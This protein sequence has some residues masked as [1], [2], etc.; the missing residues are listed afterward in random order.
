MKVIIFSGTTE[1]R[2]AAGKLS[3]KGYDITV[4]VATKLGREAMDTELSENGADIITGRLGPVELKELLKKFEVCIDATHP[5]ATEITENLK[6]V[7]KEEDVHYFRLIRD[8]YNTVSGS[9]KEKDSDMIQYVD[10]IEAAADILNDRSGNI[11]ITTGSKD[12][13]SYECLERNRLYV[14]IIPSVDGI[15]TCEEEGIP[16]KNIIA[17]WGPFSQKM[18][19][20]VI[21]QF[22]IKYVVTKDSGK[23]GGFAEKKEAAK[24][25]DCKL[26]II[27][28][29]GE[30]GLSYDELVLEL[31]ELDK[32]NRNDIS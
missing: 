1:G 6:K 13:K 29:P 31:D 27:K 9:Q 24:N 26:L 32:R 14:R 11:L 8:K 20:A 16:H 21:E 5:F 17:M 10:D 30:D 22:D 18:N 15:K 2:I 12:L 19:E 3:E 7:C 28:R 23:N 4:S 25:K